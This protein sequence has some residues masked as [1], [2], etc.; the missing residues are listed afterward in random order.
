MDATIRRDATST[1]PVKNNTYWYPSLGA[2]FII[3]DAFKIQSK[4]LSYAKIRASAAEVGNDTD[5]YQLLLTYGLEPFQPSGASIGGV[6]NTIIPNPELKPTRTKSVEFGTDLRF[7]NNRIGLEFTY[8]SQK[9]RDQ[10][11]YIDV[12]SST[13]FA[14]KILNAGTVSNKGIEILLTG[15]AIESKDISW[16]IS[17]NAAQNKNIVES[18]ASGVSYLTLSDA[19]WLGISIIAQPGLPYG[20]II[21]Y[22]YQRPDDGKIILDPTTLSPYSYRQQA[23]SGKRHMGLD[24]WC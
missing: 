19:R 20:S 9:S 6:K 2:S 8:Y 5:P 15:K 16:N 21:G 3:T 24:R 11:N 22:D 14:R 10:I 7:L 12:P 17:F 23:G 18:L 1:L 13:G 4:M